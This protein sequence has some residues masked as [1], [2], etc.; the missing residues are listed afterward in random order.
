MLLN[1]KL[2]RQILEL[3]RLHKSIWE[4]IFPIHPLFA[5]LRRIAF[6]IARLFSA[7]SQMLRGLRPPCTTMPWCIRPALAVLWGV[8]W[9]FN[10]SA[11]DLGVCNLKDEC[12]VVKKYIQM[13][14]PYC[15]FV[16][17][18]VT[19]E[20]DPFRRRIGDMDEVTDTPARAQTQQ[21]VIPTYLPT[22]Q[23]SHPGS[24]DLSPSMRG[25]PPR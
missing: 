24:S 7:V 21:A 5:M 23:P 22:P 2:R 14:D 12:D 16:I 19:R 15:V 10:P 25:H 6:E 18:D 20:M 1:A 8:C 9:M 13:T 11:W 17:E 3:E 4:C